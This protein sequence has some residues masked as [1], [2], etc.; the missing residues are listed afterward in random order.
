MRFYHGITRLVRDCHKAIPIIILIRGVNMNVMKIDCEKCFGFCCVAL[1]FSKADGFPQD[2][3]GGKP[4]SNLDNKFKCK[5]HNKLSEK[6][7]N[8]CIIY[9]CLGAGQKVAQ[10]TYE[11]I[12]WIDNVSKREEMFDVFVIMKQLYEMLW[13]LREAKN[14]NE[15]GKIK[16]DIIGL[17][18]DTLELTNLKPQE[19]LNIDLVSHRMKVNLLLKK[20]SEF[21]R[22][23]VR[24]N[25]KSTLSSK[26]QI[27][28]RINLI[29]KNLT[30]F[31]LKGE[32]L[33]GA[34]LIATNLKGVDLTG[35][36][37]IGADMRD[38]DISGANLSKALY[39]T[40]L[41]INSAK[42]DVNT[43]LPM[44]IERPSSW[45]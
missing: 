31:N 19:I 30:N 22:K 34:L 39:L 25:S 14:I 37:L 10:D 16:E 18:Q 27:G 43:K 44:N 9:D 45:K 24:G 12:N 41:Q 23:K 15:D 13:Y 36:N 11:G 6:G 42:G 32:D 3:E 29:G 33:R 5:I 2:K 26:K 20:T 4:C 40:Q 8:G 17:I 35:A 1:Y 28:G 21:V 38:T 7:L